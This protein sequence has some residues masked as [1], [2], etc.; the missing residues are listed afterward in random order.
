MCDIAQN[1]KRDVCTYE[2]SDY[3]HEIYDGNKLYDAFLK[4]KKNSSWKAR[5]HQFH[6][7]LLFELSH[8]QQELKD[9]TYELK[10]STDFILNERG[11]IRAIKGDQ[12]HDRIV[13]H[14]VCDDV[15]MPAI[16][17]K[18]IYDDGASIK[19]K[20][21]DFTRNRFTAHLQR[22]YRENHSNE[23][24][25]LL[26]DFTKYFD[27][28][29]HDVFMDLIKKYVDDESSLWLI[30][31]ILQKARIDVSYMD[32]DEY[33]NCMNTVFNSLEYNNIDK[34]LLTGDKYMSKHLD[35]GDQVSQV[36]GVLVPLR[37]DNYI[38]IVQGNKYYGRYM[39]DSYI[40]HKSKEYLE[41]LL[42]DIIKI[43]A[44]MGITVNTKKTR[45]C[46]LSDTFVFLQNRY[47]L[48]NTG[49]VVVKISKKRLT[50]MRRK[51]KKMPDQV[52]KKEFEH[53]YKS[54]F[55]NA[56][57]MMSKQQR[58]NLNA[59]YEELLNTRYDN[60][61]CDENKDHDPLILPYYFR[62]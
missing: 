14:V 19:D 7:N 43:A 48:T 8:I 20:G 36:A 54:W 17:N 38:K 42:I 27:N 30:D 41:Q 34:A 44:E 51:M 45:I 46:K 31:L 57:K 9:Q 29:R 37:L 61:D 11:K 13:K 58:K 28:I 23:G 50:R 2:W 53:W 62:K 6:M 16:K 56:Y 4:S 3:E 5:T 21:I 12:I 15:L 55:N 25:I 1:D 60:Q 10:K 40:I 33:A 47:T 59:L 22:F 39:D 35:I 18:L 49:K 52:S 26:I 32:D 24:Y